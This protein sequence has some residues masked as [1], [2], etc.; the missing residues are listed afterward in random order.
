M[1]YEDFLSYVRTK[2]EQ[3]LGDKVQVS[4]HRMAKNNGVQLDGV[5][6]LETEGKIAPTIYLNEYFRLYERGMSIPEILEQV[7]QL[8]E[9]SKV[10]IPMD[11]DFYSTFENVKEH[12]ACK[13]ISREKNEELL[14]KVPYVPYLDLAIVFYYKMESEVMGRGSILVYNSHIRM[15]N[16]SKKSVYEAAREN[17]LKLLPHTFCH[18]REMIDS[19][20]AELGE[21]NWNAMF[22]DEDAPEFP[23]YVLTNEEQCF[24]AAGIL[25]DHVLEE[26]GERLQSDFYVLPSSIHECIIVPNYVSS[27][28]D[29]LQNMVT[30]I[31]ATQVLPEEVLSDSVYFYQRKMHSLTL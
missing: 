20:Q 22:E 6:I 28:R 23:M 21:E 11:T 25:Y 15:W 1:T 5:S 10:S 29:E 7:I 19:V 16:T 2:L 8:Y 30:E 26:I 9:K 4:L 27:S 24:G 12:L 13:L 31:N 18:I 17:T 14:R 3:Q